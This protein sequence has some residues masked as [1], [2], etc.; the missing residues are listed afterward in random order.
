MIESDLS[1]LLLAFYRSVTMCKTCPDHNNGETTS[2]CFHGNAVSAG[3]AEAR[4]SNQSPE[5]RQ[6]R[7]ES[8]QH[9][10]PNKIFRCVCLCIRT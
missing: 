10:T 6:A 3:A 5:V 1:V 7:S 2:L 8:G 4:S 9:T